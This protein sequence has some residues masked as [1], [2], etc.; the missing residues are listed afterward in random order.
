MSNAFFFSKIERT[1]FVICAETK[2]CQDLAEL[3]LIH[4]LSVGQELLARV[5]S[6]KD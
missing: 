2:G 6:A 4:A 1:D 5:W 3:P